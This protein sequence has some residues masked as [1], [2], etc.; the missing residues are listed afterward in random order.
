M[1]PPSAAAALRTTALTLR[2][3]H[4]SRGSSSSSR[5]CR[6]GGPGSG[7][8]TGTANP[9][10]EAKLA[11]QLLQQPALLRS[12]AQGLAKAQILSCPYT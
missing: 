7:Q 3:S 2:Y 6:A 9:S 5:P 11:R 10:D 1:V 8:G 4:S 12:G